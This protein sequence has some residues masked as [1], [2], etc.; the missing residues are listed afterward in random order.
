MIRPE[1]LLI[2]DGCHNPQGVRAV[3]DSLR[4][5]YPEKKFTVI[6]GVMGDKDHSE[7]CRTMAEF[8]EMAYTVKPDN[9]R[10]MDAAE[11]ADELR[12]CGI[13]AAPCDSM[14]DALCKVTDKD[15]VV[16][17][18]LYMYK[19]FIEALGE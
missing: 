9:P 8:A 13:D 6:T 11:Y 4:V 2:F 10:A 17:G 19:Q 5:Y 7:M 14:E 18:S 16:L 15:T 12:L 3:A 1:P